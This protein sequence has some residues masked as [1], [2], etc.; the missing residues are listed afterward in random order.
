MS[1]VTLANYKL[2]LKV[3]DTTQDT[4]L[5]TL[6]SAVEKRVKEYLGRDL[7]SATY[8][9]E[10]YDGNDS[11]ELVLRQS[12]I[13]A[14]TTIAYYEGLDSNDAE[15]WTTLVQGSDYERK[16]ISPRL[17]SVILDTYTFVLGSQN[18]RITYTAGYSAI[19][20]DIQMACKELLKIAWDN[21]PLNKNRL[22]FLSTSDGAGGIS[23][24]LSLDPDIENKILKKIQHYRSINV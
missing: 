11:N 13:T 5:T 18:Y 8:T 17:V 9:N 22:G 24:G 21:S 15:T 16:I 14:V 12:P 2:Y 20:D 3:S 7:E 19:P 6:Q 10:L 23:Q 4:N 1:L